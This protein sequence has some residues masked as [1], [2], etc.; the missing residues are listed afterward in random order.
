MSTYIIEPV[1]INL[2][3]WDCFEYSDFECLKHETS[4]QWTC[5]ETI[6]SQIN[7]NEIALKSQLIMSIKYSVVY[8][9]VM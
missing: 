8:R 9:T 1:E 2:Y 3:N 5:G 7:M 4:I 6:T